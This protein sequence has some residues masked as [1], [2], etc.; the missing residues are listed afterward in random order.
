LTVKYGLTTPDIAILQLL[1]Q[2]VDVRALLRRIHIQRGE[3]LLSLLLNGRGII[4][5]QRRHYISTQT[6]QPFRLLQSSDQFQP[7]SFALRLLERRQ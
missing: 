5:E 2:L 3:Q 7:D 1:Q 4:R 6:R